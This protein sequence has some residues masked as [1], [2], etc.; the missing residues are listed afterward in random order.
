MICKFC[1][2]E[3]EAVVENFYRCVVTYS[4]NRNGHLHSRLYTNRKLLRAHVETFEVVVDYIA[5]IAHMSY[6]YGP[7]MTI[8][9]HDVLRL[10]DGYIA[11]MELNMDRMFDFEDEISFV[12]KIKTILLLA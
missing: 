8:S 6:D 7:A 1:N 2:K 4:P 12:A 9:I 3:A 10:D 5:Y 11:K